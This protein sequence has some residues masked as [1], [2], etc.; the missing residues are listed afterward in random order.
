MK[1]WEERGNNSFHSLYF[2]LGKVERSQFHPTME[3]KTV[4][5]FEHIPGMGINCFLLILLMVL[6]SFYL[7]P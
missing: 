7:K 2:F 5:Q 3:W 1:H 4:P 6:H